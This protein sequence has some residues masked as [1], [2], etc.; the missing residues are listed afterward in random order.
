MIRV[1]CIILFA[2]KKQWYDLRESY[3]GSRSLLYLF[4]R[5]RRNLLTPVPLVGSPTRRRALLYLRKKVTTFVPVRCLS[6]STGSFIRYVL[7]SSKARHVFTHAIHVV[8]SGRIFLLQHR[9]IRW[10]RSDWI[11]AS[12]S[13]ISKFQVYLPL[14]GGILFI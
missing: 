1:R 9:D 7:Q 4:N 5:A 3:I 11:Y 8:L 10:T 2:R 13:S 6:E 12:V 14:C